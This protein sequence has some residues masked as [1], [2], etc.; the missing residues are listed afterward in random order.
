MSLPY[1]KRYTKDFLE[2]TVGMPG[3]IKG[4]YGILLDLIYI[5]SGKLP[6]DPHYISGNLGYSVRKWNQIKK[7]LI[8][9]GKISCEN[10]IISNK[11][12][13]K[14]QIILR[15]Y[16]DN[17]AKNGAKTKKNNNLAK[18][19]ADTVLKPEPEPLKINNKN[20][21]LF[22]VLK[23]SYPKLDGDLSEAR[24][25]LDQF[26]DEGIDFDLIRWSAEQ[27]K[28]KLPDRFDTKKYQ[29]AYKYLHGLNRF[30]RERAFMSNMNAF[31]LG[32]AKIKKMFGDRGINY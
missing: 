30:M 17:Q 31:Q 8:E 11:R 12:A 7:E 22:D 14:E 2:G 28:V 5:Q 13:D 3:E 27:V 23:K 9:R 29:D 10:G 19:A 26:I 18:A 16:Q 6:D 15:T 4:A 24:L 32:E 20:D 1:Y 25:L 21:P